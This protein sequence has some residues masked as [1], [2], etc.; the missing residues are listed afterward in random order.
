MSER[1]S[2]RERFLITEDHNVS[3]RLPFFSLA[4]ISSFVLVGLIA[5]YPPLYSVRLSGQPPFCIL[6]LCN[7]YWTEDVDPAEW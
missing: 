2:E 7:S 5:T 6:T 1:A 4:V 3:T